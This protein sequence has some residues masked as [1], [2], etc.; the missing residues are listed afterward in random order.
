MHYC[1][2]RRQVSLSSVRRTKGD[3]RPGRRRTGKG[4]VSVHSDSR[5]FRELHTRCQVFE[6]LICIDARLHVDCS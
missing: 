2:S 4:N 5:A 3:Q 1:Y 6:R